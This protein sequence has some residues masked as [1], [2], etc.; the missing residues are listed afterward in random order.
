MMKSI[1]LVAI[2]LCFLSSCK[3]EEGN[4]SDLP[5]GTVIDVT[6]DLLIEAETTWPD[7]YSDDRPDY[8]F[9]K[10]VNVAGIL[11]IEPGVKIVFHQNPTSLQGSTGFIVSGLMKANGTSANPI[12]IEGDGTQQ[13]LSGVWIHSRVSEPN[14]FR[15]CIFDMKGSV[16]SDNRATGVLDFEANNPQIIHAAIENCQFIGGE[17]GIRVCAG[18]SLDS[19]LSNRC[20]NNSNPEYSSLFNFDVIDAVDNSSSFAGNVSDKIGIAS[21]HWGYGLV[22]IDNNLVVH[23]LDSGYYYDISTSA[24]L[25]NTFVIRNGSVSIEPGVEINGLPNFRCDY[26]EISTSG[27]ATQGW[28]Y[29][30]GG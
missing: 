5:P 25:D 24:G 11:N 14:Q 15:Y 20:L 2:A 16:N 26:G 28:Y 21:F 1:I 9:D 8:E 17:L 10:N 4:T 22:Y 7:K 3:K 30:C 13:S 19:F 18:I 12:Y 29:S 23:K 27:N 6:G